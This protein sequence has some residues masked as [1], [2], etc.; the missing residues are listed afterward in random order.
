[1][2]DKLCEI[3]KM[4]GVSKCEK[5]IGSLLYNVATTLPKQINKLEHQKVLVKYIGEEKIINAHRYGMAIDYLMGKHE[6]E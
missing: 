1:M 2:C 5:K 4:S 6:V 3:I